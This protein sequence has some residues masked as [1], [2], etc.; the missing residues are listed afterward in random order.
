MEINEYALESLVQQRL[1][2]A[3]A[4]T[5]RR[6]LVLR[7]RPPRVALRSRVGAALIA[8]GEHLAGT[9]APRPSAAPSA[10][11]G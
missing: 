6:S 3:R 11:H 4:L 2:A 8:L 9:P 7:A 5:A 10:S 1:S